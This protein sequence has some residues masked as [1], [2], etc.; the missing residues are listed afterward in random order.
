MV[1]DAPRRSTPRGSFAGVG[2]ATQPRRAAIP[3]NTLFYR[4]QVKTAAK[5]RKTR[6]VCT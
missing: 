5:P 6:R 4:S 2:Q 1:G 3:P